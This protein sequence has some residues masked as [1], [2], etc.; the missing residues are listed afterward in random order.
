[1][2]A[3]FD[4]AGATAKTLAEQLDTIAN[5]VAR[6]VESW[7]GQSA[8]SHA[9]TLEQ[10]ALDIHRVADELM[11]AS[12]AC[13][14]QEAA[15]AK[16]A[17]EEAT[18]QAVQEA[19]A[20]LAD[21][22]VKAAAGQMTDMDLMAVMSEYQRLKSQRERALAEHTDATTNT[23]I[24]EA[25]TSTLPGLGEYSSRPGA[26][27]VAESLLTPNGASGSKSGGL[28]EMGTD[29]DDATAGDTGLID[30]PDTEAS[31]EG[32]YTPDTST[33]AAAPSAAAS[34]SGSP[35]PSTGTP[36]L[37]DTSDAASTGLS[38]DSRAVMTPQAGALGGAMPMQQQPQQMTGG[39]SPGFTTAGNMIGQPQQSAQPA[40]RGGGSGFGQQTPERG[41][42]GRLTEG[43]IS[44]ILGHSGA[45]VAGATA[46]AAAAGAAPSAG[47]APSAAGATPP[48][49]PSAPAAASASPNTPQPGGGGAGGVAPM[50][51]MGSGA[52]A[53]TSPQSAAPKPEPPK[54]NRDLLERVDDLLKGSGD[55]KPNP[56]H[57]PKKKAS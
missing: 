55:P 22:R 12:T 5:A 35:A 11:D 16:L 31:G 20:A 28:G 47:T 24:P 14:G 6:P 41:S 52:R 54:V 3:G 39:G 27:I 15:D 7:A 56:D 44:A 9:E 53:A 34:A 43:G 10:Y 2:T 40:R 13:D 8:E 36:S 29:N 23:A 38:T 46:G 18:P 19:A 49:T 42:D 32:W 21:A 33:P 51:A 37:S 50:G 17:A 30:A 4:I 26:D 57:D 25:E 45:A 48:S 1:M